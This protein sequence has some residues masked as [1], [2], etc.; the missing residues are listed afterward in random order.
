MKYVFP[1]CSFGAEELVLSIPFVVLAF[2]YLFQPDHC[3]Y[4]PDFVNELDLKKGR[5]LIKIERRVE[6]GLK[7][8]V[9]GPMYIII[10]LASQ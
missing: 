1:S 10:V 6:S 8:N 9:E 2:I 5:D 3:V 4:V 7:E